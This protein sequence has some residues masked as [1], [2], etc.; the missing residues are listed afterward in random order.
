MTL[1]PGEQILSGTEDPDWFRAEP[2]PS[3]PQ[4]PG[5]PGRWGTEGESETDRAC[6]IV[7]LQNLEHPQ[8]LRFTGDSVCR[9]V[10]RLLCQLGQTEEN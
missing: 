2:D 6:G 10:C 5:T 3:P 9:L 1:F 8:T 7:C 4:P